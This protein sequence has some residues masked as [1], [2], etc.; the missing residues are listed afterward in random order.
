[1][2]ISLQNYTQTLPT[3]WITQFNSTCIFKHDSLVY[4][5]WSLQLSVCRSIWWFKSV[6]AICRAIGNI[7]QVTLVEETVCSLG[8]KAIFK[9]ISI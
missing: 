1:M 2:A 5:P 7:S 8:L 3:F 9:F 6:T 4:E